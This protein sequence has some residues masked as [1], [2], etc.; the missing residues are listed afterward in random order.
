MAL[1][2]NR[3]EELERLQR[4]L[5]SHSPIPQ[6]VLEAALLDPNTEVRMAA[7]YEISL[8]MA[9]PPLDLLAPVL[10]GDPSA[11]VRLEALTIVADSDDEQADALIRG[12]LDDPDEAVRSEALDQVEARSDDS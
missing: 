11:E 4:Q 9:E 8:E 7:L 10:Q 6:S 1:V 5:Q 3:P 2:A 12:S